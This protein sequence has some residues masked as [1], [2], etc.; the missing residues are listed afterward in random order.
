MAYGMSCLEGST[1]KEFSRYNNQLF[2]KPKDERRVPSVKY[3]TLNISDLNTVVFEIPE[4]LIRKFKS[5]GWR[6]NFIPI[7]TFKY[8]YFVGL[9]HTNFF[10]Q[11]FDSWKSGPLSISM[12]ILPKNAWVERVGKVRMPN[13]DYALKVNVG[14]LVGFK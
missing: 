7:V 4:Q 1:V 12:A 2:L 5:M 11:R 14:V 9:M 8:D 13:S 3:I 6:F 10:D